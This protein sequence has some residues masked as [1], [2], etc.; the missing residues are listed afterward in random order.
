[1]EVKNVGN[2]KPILVNWRP[3]PS[4]PA[5]FVKWVEVTFELD[6]LGVVAIRPSILGANVQTRCL[7][8]SS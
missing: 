5:I 8:G 2:F 4:H 6:L 7:L 3:L 1:M